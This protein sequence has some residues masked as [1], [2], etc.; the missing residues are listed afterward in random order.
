MFSLPTLVRHIVVWQLGQRRC[1]DRESIFNA[2]V[3]SLLLF[4]SNIPFHATFSL[5]Q[6]LK[7]FEQYFAWT[8]NIVVVASDEHTNGVNVT[9]TLI[10]QPKYYKGNGQQKV[11][12]LIP[13]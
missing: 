2:Q 3:V 10:I 8:H 1:F 7:L 4:L 13:D 5:E 12:I 6:K 11:A 9:K